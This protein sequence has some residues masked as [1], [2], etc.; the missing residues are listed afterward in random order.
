M[1]FK[2]ICCCFDWSVL[3]FAR[4]ARFAHF[5]RFSFARFARLHRS[6]PYTECSSPSLAARP[7]RWSL[8][9]SLERIHRPAMHA[10]MHACIQQSQYIRVVQYHQYVVLHACTTTTTTTTT[11]SLR[12]IRPLPPQQFNLYHL[13]RTHV[14]AKQVLQREMTQSQ[15]LDDLDAVEQEPDPFGTVALFRSYICISA[16]LVWS[17]L[18]W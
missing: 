1:G 3:H 18:V 14:I 7:N 11:K 6:V 16:G 17:G 15:T 12:F 4:F 13:G 9:L 2:W 10:C 8:A 5:A